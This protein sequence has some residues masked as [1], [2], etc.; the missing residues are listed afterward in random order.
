MLARQL[1]ARI[2]R[3]QKRSLRGFSAD[4]ED[5]I[6]GH[7]WPGNVRELENRTKCAVIMAEG[8][9]VTAADMGLADKPIAQASLN[10]EA[11]CKEAE[12]KAVRLA[13]V[14][15]CGDVSRAAQ[16]L[17]LRLPSCMV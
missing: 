6:Q 2:T 7:N 13:M 8:T 11:I 5:A 14:R 3:Q 16:L 9:H 12:H 1:F 10:L 17:G 4:A 15:T